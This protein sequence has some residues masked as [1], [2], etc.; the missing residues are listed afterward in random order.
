MTVCDWREWMLP[1]IVSTVREHPLLW[2]LRTQL[3]SLRL[4][5][6]SDSFCVIFATENRGGSVLSLVSQLREDVKPRVFLAPVQNL[7]LILTFLFFF[8]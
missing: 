3:M 2:V 8:S 5:K 4:S 6:E 7:G 1:A